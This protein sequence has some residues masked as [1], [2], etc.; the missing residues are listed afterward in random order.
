MSTNQNR[1]LLAALLTAVP[2]LL[3]FPGCT[4]TVE[5]PAA[6]RLSIVQ[7]NLQQAAAGTLLP[8]QVVLRV[9]AADGSPVAK[10]PVS[11]N[12]VAGGGIV[13]PPSVVSDANGEVK[14][15][16]TLGPGFQSQSVSGN[17]PGVDPVTLQA[18]GILPSDLMVAQGNNQSAKASAAL[19][20]QIVIRVTG[21]SNVPIPNQTVALAVTTGGGSISPQSAVT[22]ALGEVTVRW[23]LGPSVGL[24]SATVSAGSLGPIPISAVAN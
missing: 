3:A 12:V 21:G 19:P 5:A 17:A 20:V 6:S 16:W 22:N 4:K 23:T 1:Y 18:F 11:F 2:T 15:K 13:D 14:A 10:V 24:Q 9:Y 8:T 7:G